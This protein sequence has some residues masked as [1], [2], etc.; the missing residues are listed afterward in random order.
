MTKKRVS[1]FCIT[2][3]ICAFGACGPK[4]GEATAS[5]FNLEFRVL[6]DNGAPV[7]GARIRAGDR[8]LG[9][10]DDEGNLPSK[11][12]GNEGQILV[13]SVECPLGFAAPEKPASLRLA[14]I[15]N[16]NQDRFQPTHLDM[17]CAREVTEV[18]LLVRAQGGPGLPVQVEGTASATTNSEGIAHVLLRVSRKMNA[19]NV[20]LDTSTHQNLRPK[21]PTRVYEL[22]GR[23]AILIL[24]QTFVTAPR[25][26]HR[27]LTT[28]PSKHIPYRVD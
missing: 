9:S 18:V 11:L 27:H 8:S 26:V 10:T 1:M 7:K 20:T 14:R 13:I 28:K 15:R 4:N 2:A 19:V 5:S 23:D 17:T 21:N 12:L 16:I 3:M 25:A 6:S 24:D 22:S